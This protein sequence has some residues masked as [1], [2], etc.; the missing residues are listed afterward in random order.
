MQINSPQIQIAKN[1]KSIDMNQKTGKIITE[2]KVY[3]LSSHG[4]LLSCWAGLQ[5]WA[6]L[7]VK[8]TNSDRVFVDLNF[9]KI[10]LVF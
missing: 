9:T 4:V 10:G 7:P 1:S 8:S 3:P 2:L 5:K 6:R